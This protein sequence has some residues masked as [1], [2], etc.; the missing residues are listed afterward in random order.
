MYGIVAGHGWFNDLG[1]DECSM[2]IE[3]DGEQYVVSAELVEKE[4]KI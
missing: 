2:S 1:D 3:V 4:I